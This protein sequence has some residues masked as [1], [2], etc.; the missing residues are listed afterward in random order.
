MLDYFPNADHAGHL[1]G[2]GGG[3]VREGRASTSRSRRRRIPSAPLKLLLAGRTDL[4][5][6][7][8]P[9]LLLARDKGAELVAVGALVQK[10]L[11]SLMSVGKAGVRTPQ[12]LRGKRVGTAGIP[13]QSAYLKTILETAGRRPGRRSR[14]RTSA[15]TSCRRCSSGKVDATLGAFWN[16]EGVDLERRGRDPVIQRDRAARRADLRR[17]RVRRAPARPRRGRSARGV[18]RFMQATARGHAALQ[19]RPAAGLDGLLEADPGLDRGLQEA[20]VEATLPVFFPADPSAPFGYQDPAEWQRYA[21]WMLDERADH[22]AAERRAGA[23]QRVPGRRGARPRERS[24]R[25]DGEQ[26]ARRGDAQ[27]LA[28][29]P[30]PL[31]V[32]REERAHLRLVG[33][34]LRVARGHAADE[35]EVAEVARRRPGRGGPGRSRRASRASRARCPGSRAAAASRARIVGEQVDAARTPPRRPR[36]AGSARGPA[37]GPSPP[38]ARAPAPATAAGAGASR[39]PVARAARARAR[40]SAAAGSRPRA[41]TRSAA[42]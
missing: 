19:G 12:D 38:A 33:A 30:L 34:R 27:V 4:A 9:E 36:A 41:R 29:E 32:G 17:A 10:P 8:E 37:R 11:T 18:R 6:S 25:T 35:L 2:A 31:A 3:R 15:S 13:Y 42:R 16:Y 20:A 5:I 40:R 28:G 21:D 39:S 23:D 7:Y 24:R 22:A 26:P 14:R 1:R